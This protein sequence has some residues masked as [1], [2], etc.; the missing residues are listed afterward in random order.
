MPANAVL[1]VHDA[2]PLGEVVLAPAA[3]TGRPRAEL[4][5]SM[6]QYLQGAAPNTGAEALSLLRRMFPDTPLADRVAALA[7]AMRR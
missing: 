3:L 2:P 6:A 4:A 5:H 7:A 1:I